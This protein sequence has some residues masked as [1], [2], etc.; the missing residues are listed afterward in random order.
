MS[1]T[2]ELK[3]SGWRWLV[4]S[5]RYVYRFGKRILDEQVETRVRNDLDN[6]TCSCTDCTDKAV[7]IRLLDA[8]REER[9]EYRQ[10]IQDM[11][12]KAAANK[13][14][15]YRE[16]GN[17]CAQFENELDKHRDELNAVRAEYAKTKEAIEDYCH[18]CLSD[19][20]YCSDGCVLSSVEIAMKRIT[21]REG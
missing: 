5:S 7:L 20:S 8:A 16:L 11:V 17:K 18:H 3:K 21:T 13:L 9:D 19:G 12:D 4:V 2:T 10:A 14:D 6:T 15:G 1:G